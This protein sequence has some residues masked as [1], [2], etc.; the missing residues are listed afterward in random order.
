MALHELE[1]RAF[2]LLSDVVRHAYGTDPRWARR[3]PASPR[4]REAVDHVR[5]VIATRPDA[6]LPLATLAGAVY[7]TGLRVRASLEP[8]AAGEDLTSIAL[9]LGFVSHSHFTHAFSQVFGVAP[10]SMRSGSRRG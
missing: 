10:S 3:R 8:I 1:E 9:A 5:Q 4:V 6:R 2:A 7:R